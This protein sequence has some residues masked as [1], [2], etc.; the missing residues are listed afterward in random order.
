MRTLERWLARYRD[1]GV[2]AFA[3]R[4]RVDRGRRRMPAVLCRM[5]EGFA[6]QRPAH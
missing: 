4:D 3:R 6:L 2:I 1:G 5:I